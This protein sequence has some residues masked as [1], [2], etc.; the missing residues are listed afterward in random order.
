MEIKLTIIHQMIERVLCRNLSLIIKFRDFFTTHK[1]TKCIK[2]LYDNNNFTHFK[3]TIEISDSK[4][5]GLKTEF[6]QFRFI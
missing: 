4:R 6:L 2:I 5:I 3:H 1:L